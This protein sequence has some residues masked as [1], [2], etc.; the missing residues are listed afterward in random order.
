MD[1]T[2]PEAAAHIDEVAPDTLI[3]LRGKP[4]TRYDPLPSAGQPS[5]ATCSMCAHEH[6][7]FADGDRADAPLICLGCVARLVAEGGVG[8]RHV[9]GSL[10]SIG[11]SRTATPWTA[12]L[13]TT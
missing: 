10:A 6:R 1:R 12:T 2:P 7:C 3:A 9:P 11:R 13:P 5:F 4:G 8:Q